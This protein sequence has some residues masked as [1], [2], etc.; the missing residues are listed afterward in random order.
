M[1][2]RHW[3]GKRRVRECGPEGNGCWFCMRDAL[4]RKVLMERSLRRE[5]AAL[6]AR[7]QQEASDG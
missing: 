1:G 4:K 2:R 3:K 7:N 6:S 5:K